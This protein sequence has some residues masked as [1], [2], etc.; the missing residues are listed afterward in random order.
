MSRSKSTKNKNCENSEPRYDYPKR[1]LWAHVADC[2]ESFD[3]N[4]EHIVR[5]SIDYLVL[6]NDRNEDISSYKK[7]V[8]YENYVQIFTIEHR[9]V[10][11]Q[12]NDRLAI[13]L[14]ETSPISRAQIELAIDNQKINVEFL[15]SWS[16]LHILLDQYF[17][18]L[19]NS[20]KYES[21]FDQQFNA[22]LE[23]NVANQKLW[24]ARWVSENYSELLSSKDF[25]DAKL[26][27]AKNEI[28]LLC[29]AIVNG[30]IAC[31]EPF[32][33]AWFKKL[34]N[35]MQ[36]DELTSRL[37][38]LGRTDIQKLAGSSDIPTRLLPPLNRALFPE[39]KTTHP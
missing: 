30:R 37:Q 29:E 1:N 18:I 15:R 16:E 17:S 2:L 4:V 19:N 22:G 23:S 32:K 7:S 35:P 27:E 14:N 39:L 24:F 33:T 21:R 3:F 38:K 28:L 5:I 8:K 26:D 6:K 20:T 11:D 13:F 36:P 12:F 31:P 9:E 10:I 25:R 34:L